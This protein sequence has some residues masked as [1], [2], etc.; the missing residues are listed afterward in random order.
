MTKQEEIFVK[1]I[2][3]NQVK[4]AGMVEGLIVQLMDMVQY[5][6]DMAYTI[7]QPEPEPEETRRENGTI[8]KSRVVQTE[9]EPE[10]EPEIVFDGTVQDANAD[11]A[12]DIQTVTTIAETVEKPKKTF[13]CGMCGKEYVKTSNSQKYCPDCRDEARREASRK[14]HREAYRRK[15]E[16]KPLSDHGTALSVAECQRIDREHGVSYG[17]GELMGL[18]KKEART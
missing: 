17:Q 3:R 6:E 15:A 18:H 1:T 12:K 4:L 14:C 7:I 9:D 2:F 11:S 5:T 16:A 13:L 8:R 10:S